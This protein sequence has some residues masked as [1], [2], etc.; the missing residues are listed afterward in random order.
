MMYANNSSKSCS[1]NY[2]ITTEVL[3]WS[4]TGIMGAS[5]IYLN[6]NNTPWFTNPAIKTGNT[7]SPL[8][9]ETFPDWSFGIALPVTLSSIIFL[10]NNDGHLNHTS[11]TNAKGFTETIV[12]TSL[13]TQIAKLSIG[14]K[15]P[16]YNDRI[17]KNYNIT[18]GLYSFWSGHA[19]MSFSI[20]TYTSLYIMEHVGHWNNYYYI[21]G[22]VL[23]SSILFGMATWTSAS[24]VENNRHY[25]SDVV[26]GSIIGSLIAFTIY[27]IQNEWFFNRYN[28]DNKKITRFNF[29]LQP[30]IIALS[31]SY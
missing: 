9:E 3:E 23:S 14:R 27:G 28:H 5:T 19:A 8:Q 12:I 15:R 11:Y 4:I 7:N 20:A 29:T 31:Y 2:N 26:V 1:I 16:D 18:D 30:G 10:P 22:K 13:T 24:R 6:L 25:T 21:T 17:N